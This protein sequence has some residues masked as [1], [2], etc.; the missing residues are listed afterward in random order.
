[1]GWGSGSGAYYDYGDNVY[2]QDSVVYVDGNAVATADEYATQAQQI[3]ESDVPPEG[4]DI[5]WMPLGTFGVLTDEDQKE[6]TMV[7]QLAVAKDGFISGTYFNTSSDSAQPVQG[8]VDRETQRAAWTVGENKN[9][10]IETG[11]YNLT[12]DQTPVLVHF[13]KD[14][15]QTWMMVRL[16]DPNAE[17]EKE[18][19]KK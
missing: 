17:K 15:T 8:G 9:T 3:A 19:E 5:E 6:P 14:R 10:V 16:E 1:M 13:G 18:R 2:Y 11:V 4:S 7:F 12:K